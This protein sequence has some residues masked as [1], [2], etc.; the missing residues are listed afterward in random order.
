MDEYSTYC[1]G[2][3]WKLANNQE[4]S[5]ASRA[6]ERLQAAFALGAAHAAD[7]Q[8]AEGPTATEAIGDKST[9][10]SILNHMLK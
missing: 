3:A 1:F 7:S 5:S 4:G 6:T 10:A 8:R 2:F 9:V